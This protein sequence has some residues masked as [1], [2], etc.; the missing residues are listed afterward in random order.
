MMYAG[1][2]MA[3][4][5]IKVV[6]G[7]LGIGGAEKHLTYIFPQLVKK[8]W[9]V[10]VITLSDTNDLKGILE[11]SDI[12]VLSPN[13]NGFF[14]N[15]KIKFIQRF[16]RLSISLK[17]LHKEFRKDKDA[18]LHFYLPEAYGLGM[19]VAKFLQTKS[20]LI[21]SRRSLNNYQKR[22]KIL[23]FFERVFHKNLTAA[24]VNS[25]AI[26]MQLVEEGVKSERIKLIYNGIPESTKVDNLPKA[27]LLSNFGVSANDVIITM[28]ANLIPYKGHSD[29]INALSLVKN[30]VDENWK[31]LLIGNDRGILNNLKTLAESL[32]VN[33]NII[34]LDGVT[35]VNPYLSVS[36]IFILPSHEE[37]F[38][39]A[40][41]EA[42][43]MELPVIATN[44]GGNSEAVMNN[45]S[46][47]VIPPHSP[48]EIAK[49]LVL[50]I[51][52]SEMR[53]RYGIAG[54]ARVEKEFSL[55]GCVNKYD[56]FY[57]N[58]NST[59]AAL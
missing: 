32:G 25:N 5:L 29:L 45:E 21:M 30:E 6:I 44:V 52:D 9:K 18:M 17:H 49:A 27:E 14:C 2:E 58:I 26:A 51:T 24:L 4:K 46:G 40:I 35:D 16:S 28:V 56:A 39:N 47:L 34:W 42:M 55:M 41:L 53:R 20:P 38:S 37:G 8:G 23:S 48:K 57:S 31:M 54:K 33:K 15:H 36:D 10:Q 13:F 22:R 11:E 12:A 1:I 7:G 19:L 3:N 43:N 50:L 59:I